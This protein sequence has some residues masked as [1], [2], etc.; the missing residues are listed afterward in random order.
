MQHFGI[1]REKRLI[2]ELS[3]Q[4]IVSVHL[5]VLR[6][7]AAVWQ[8]NKFVSASDRSKSSAVIWHQQTISSVHLIVRNQMQ[9][10]D[11][12]R[13]L[14]QCIWSFGVGCSFSDINR[15][16]SVH[17]MASTSNAVLATFSD[18]RQRASGRFTIKCSILT[19]KQSSVHLMTSTSDAVLTIKQS[20]EHLIVSRSN[21]VFLASHSFDHFLT[22]SGTVER[23]SYTF[24]WSSF[25]RKMHQSSVFQSRS[26]S[27]RTQHMQSQR[28]ISEIETV[29]QHQNTFSTFQQIIISTF[30]QMIISN[31]HFERA[32]RASNGSKFDLISFHLRSIFQFFNCF[33]LP[34]SSPTIK[35]QQNGRWCVSNKENYE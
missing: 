4:T 31:D 14:R 15:Q 11:I 22:S 19:S 12:N 5:I 7:N 34:S 10:F 28:K 1:H 9:S 16:S 20:S 23:P 24:I 33:L 18:N 13:Q 17:L 25:F 6:S 27:Y 2:N 8:S 35:A 21:A 30:H 32:F 3:Q 26:L 29:N